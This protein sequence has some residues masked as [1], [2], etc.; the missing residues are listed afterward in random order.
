MPVMVLMGVTLR[1]MRMP[2]GMVVIV[3]MVV[4]MVHAAAVGGGAATL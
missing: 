2:V 4:A 1:G 3:M